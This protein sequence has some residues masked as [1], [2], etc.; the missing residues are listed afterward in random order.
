MSD[1]KPYTYK[2]EEIERLRR[3]LE[4]RDWEI[5]AIQDR[6]CEVEMEWAAKVDARDA[7]IARLREEM[8][9]TAGEAL[10]RPCRRVRRQSPTDG[11]QRRVR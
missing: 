2:Q 6:A 9:R 3:V 1:A 11:S 8:E 5:H 7:E 10:R 4:V